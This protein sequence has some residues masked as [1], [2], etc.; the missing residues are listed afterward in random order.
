M[1]I[2]YE[3]VNDYKQVHDFAFSTPGYLQKKA[4]MFLLICCVLV[5]HLFPSSGNCLGNDIDE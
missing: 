3:Q 4:V 2:H 1:V 5:L